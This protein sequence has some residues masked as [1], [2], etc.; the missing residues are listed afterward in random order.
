MNFNFFPYSN[1]QIK[2]RHNSKMLYHTYIERLNRYS[3][4]FRYKMLWQKHKDGYELLVKQ[5]QISNKREYLGKRDDKTEKIASDFT[6]SK[7]VAKE[8]LKQF[9]TKLQ[10]DEKLNKLEGIAR[11]PNELVDIFRKINELGLDDKLIV[12]GTNSLYAYEAKAGVAIEEEHLA[13]HDIDIL[14]RKEKGLSFIF[15]EL[16]SPTYAIEFLQM[17]D[18]SFYQSPNRPYRFIND[19]GVWIELINPV[20]DSVSHPMFKDN[21]FSDVTP[22]AMNGIHWLENSR[23]FKETVIANNGKSAN[24]T[25][26]HPLEYAIYKNWL[27][28]REDRDFQKHTRDIEQSRLV[29]KLIV[30]YMPNIDIEEDVWKLKHFKREIVEEYMGEIYAKL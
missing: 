17:I 12:I 15:K 14:N 27:G 20:S 3:L 5:N 10:R 13:T 16:M 26:I 25:T 28:K 18:K 9:K 23:L 1:L 19:S 29:T 4:Q 21:L 7:K 30:E 6:E 11:T 24:I 22:L 8:Q 2:Q